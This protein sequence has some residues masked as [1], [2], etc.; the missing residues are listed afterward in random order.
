MIISGEMS[1]A[2]FKQFYSKLVEA[3]P[4]NDATFV[5]KLYS[6]DLLSCKLKNELNLLQKTSAVK[7]TIF[8]DNVIEPSVTI[9][10]G[11]SFDTLLNVMEDSECLGVKELANQIRAIM[12]KRS[13]SDHG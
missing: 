4:M 13:N 10:G 9:D 12:R 6:C 3:L 11:S 5:A 2:V 8:L 7:A 1:S